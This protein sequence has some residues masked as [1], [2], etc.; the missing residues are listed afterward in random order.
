MTKAT[1]L[2]VAGAAVALAATGIS[3]AAPASADNVGGGTGAQGPFVTASISFTGDVRGGG[4]T[5]SVS[6]PAT[7][8]WEPMGNVVL[9]DP[10]VD[11][12]DP[13]SV[14][15]YFEYISRF[16]S[17][18]AAGGRLEI[19]S[20][21][22]M[23]G[24][25]R[26]VAAGEELTFYHATCV[27][28][29]NAVD[30]GLIDKSGT[31][32]GLDFGVTFAA[33]PPGAE[34]E[35]IVAAETLA[36]EALK[37]LFI[38]N[39]AVDRN[40]KIGLGG[41]EAAL[42]TLPTY[43]WVTNPGDAL[44]DPIGHKEVVAT[45]GDAQATLTADSTGIS[46]SAPAGALEDGGRQCDAETITHEY[47]SGAAEGDLCSVKFARA[48]VGQ[49]AGWPVTVASHWDVA[50]TGVEANGDV[51]PGGP[52]ALLNPTQSTINVPVAE[53]QAVVESTES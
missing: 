45:A 25:A 53:S 20:A 6:V 40:P 23:A 4:G 3:V 18:H 26:R 27:D 49:G 47:S 51:N 50:W 19:P 8:W 43:F 31:W 30:E 38:E 39:P 37:V 12:D 15:A 16:L 41:T 36:Q 22:Y 46:I 29:K 44:G 7:C 10:P 28:G 5:R 17:G 13:A 21:D 1:K 48:S 32:E 2:L 34:P 14:E 24:I 52:L 42:V 11:P 35:P 9:G 33:F